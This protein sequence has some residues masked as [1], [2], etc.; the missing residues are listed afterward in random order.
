LRGHNPSC[1]KSNILYNIFEVCIKDCAIYSESDIRKDG[2]SML[3]Q[4]IGNRIR[5]VRRK[6]GLRLAD[7]ASTSGFSAGLLSKIERGKVSSPVS[8]LGVIAKALGTSFEQIAGNEVK[9]ESRDDSEKISIVKKSERVHHNIVYNGVLCKYEW[10]APKVDNKLM[11]PF[12]HTLPKEHASQ[13]YS[14]HPGQEMIFVLQG[15]LLFSY[16]RQNFLLEEGDC[17]YYDSSI[18]HR[19]RSVGDKE[20]KLLC[21]RSVF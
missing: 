14:H 16:R 11:E 15:R 8:T 10:L 7:L 1:I 9:Q 20:L 19:V 5:E 13:I 6:K 2:S 4:Q 18:A 12:I 17:A 3:E 21:I